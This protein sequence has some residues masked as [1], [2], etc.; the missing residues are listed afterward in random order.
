MRAKIQSPRCLKT[1][2]QN[3]F[4]GLTALLMGMILIAN[5]AQA[6]LLCSESFKDTA[7]TVGTYPHKAP[8]AE[9]SLLAQKNFDL[10][11]LTQRATGDKAWWSQ[12]TQALQASDVSTLSSLYEHIPEGDYRRAIRLLMVGEEQGLKIPAQLKNEVA[13]TRQQRDLLRSKD[14]EVAGEL[15]PLNLRDLT[16]MFTML[17]IRRSKLE[18]MYERAKKK[19]GYESKE[20]IPVIQAGKAEGI[21]GDEA[22]LVLQ[23]YNLRVKVSPESTKAAYASMM[24]SLFALYSQRIY[25]TLEEPWFKVDGQQLNLLD[26]VKSGAYRQPEIKSTNT[27]MNVVTLDPSKVQ[28]PILKNY[29]REMWW[30]RLN[31]IN[32]IGTV[33]IARNMDVDQN[34][35]ETL[36]SVEVLRKGEDGFYVPYLFEADITGQLK[37]V[38]GKDALRRM[39][40]C[41]QCHL[42]LNG[43]LFGGI[44]M[45]GYKAVDDWHINNIDFTRRKFY[46]KFKEFRK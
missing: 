19:L 7:N 17:G 46:D 1:I 21:L 13:S 33:R 43:I 11:I 18:R 4:L 42:R 6:Q 36:H 5:T 31:S 24:D 32:P 2:Q 37:P 10:F 34:G 8:D 38:E 23:E 41:F 27:W 9:M 44:T 12:A 14:M 40:A 30:N 25:K 20:L 39:E 45:K 28:N 35:K 16:N 29:T 3:A 15:T 26:F 22:R